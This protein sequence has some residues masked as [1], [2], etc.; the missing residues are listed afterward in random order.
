M[1]IEAKAL[2][3]I[4]SVDAILT[5]NDL[6]TIHTDGT[7]RKGREYGGL[8]IGTSTGQFSVGISES[9]QGNADS[10][11]TMIKEICDNLG[12]LAGANNNEDKKSAEIFLKVNNMMTDRHVVNNCLKNML[13]KWRS[14][15]LPQ[16]A[17][18]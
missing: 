8:Q 5:S 16:I 10:F 7:Q 4:Q 9:V 17:C 3:Q 15:C 1:L 13:E 14:D 18:I 6:C 11:F 12:D 2:A